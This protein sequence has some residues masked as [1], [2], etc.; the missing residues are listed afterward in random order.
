MADY[1]A[2]QPKETSRKRENIEW[3]IS[4][5][6]NATDKSNP[7]V[8][9]IGD[10]ICNDYQRH[11]RVFL[12]DTCNVS[13][14]ASS[15]CV[16]DPDYFREL[17]FILDAYDYDVIT[18]NNGLHS[19]NTNREEWKAAYRSAV[20]FVQEKTKAPVFLV[21]STPLKVPELTALS[22]ELNGYTREIAEEMHL[23]VIDLFSLMDPLDREEHW[24]DSHHFREPA[25]EMQ[26]KCI[27]EH[28]KAALGQRAA[29]VGHAATATGPDGAIE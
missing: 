29:N 10:S 11:A 24:R 18:F 4:Y 2:Y 5:A 9:L 25:I 27:C 12:E 21:L 16:T 15:K 7:R 14:W 28:V 13:F 8:L 17:N 1:K 20:K 19:L 3:S 23:P 26:G 22:K 6:F